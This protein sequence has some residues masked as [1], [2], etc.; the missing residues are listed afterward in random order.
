MTDQ[1]TV[2]TSDVTGR[3]VLAKAVLFLL[4]ASAVGF[5]VSMVGHI[6]GW[7]GF[8]NGGEST[9]AGDTFW[10]LY[11][12]AGIAALVVGVVALVRGLRGGPASERQA[13][14]WALGYVVASV[15]LI[16]IVDALFE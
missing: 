9:A 12:F 2:N 3:S 15:A 14:T 11:F 10:L 6:A 1:G 4:A 7:K 8:D 5:A 16:A 13:G